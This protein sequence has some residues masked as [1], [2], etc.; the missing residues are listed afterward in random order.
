MSS[1]HSRNTDDRTPVTDLLQSLFG[2]VF[3]DRGY[4][5]KKLAQE[6]L[7][8]YGIEFFAKPWRNMNMLLSIEA[9]KRGSAR[10]SRFFKG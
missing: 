8:T 7:E 3:A 6:L 2:K 10:V 9:L 4:V 1:S 5:S